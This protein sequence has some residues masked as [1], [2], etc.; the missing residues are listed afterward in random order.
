MDYLFGKGVVLSQFADTLNE[1]TSTP[2]QWYHPPQSSVFDRYLG[3]ELMEM[4]A[5]HLRRTLSPFCL[6]LSVLSFN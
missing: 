5:I 2:K 3:L 1:K 4:A 6:E